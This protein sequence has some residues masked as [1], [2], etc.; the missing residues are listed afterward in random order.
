MDSRIDLPL[1]DR[2]HPVHAAAVAVGLLQGV[3]QLHESA[4]HLAAQFH[5]RG[6]CHEQ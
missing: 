4:G 1:Q 2:D 3:D 6:V 5:I